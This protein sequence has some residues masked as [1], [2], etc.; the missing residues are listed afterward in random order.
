MFG[1]DT[2]HLDLMAKVFGSLNSTKIFY[3]NGLLIK[4]MDR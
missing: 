3:K 4:K 2:F 1:R